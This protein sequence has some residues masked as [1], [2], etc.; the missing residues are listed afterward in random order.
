MTDFWKDGLAAGDAAVKKVIELE[1]ARQQGGIELIASEN[2]VSAAVLEAQGSILTNKYAEGYPGKRY[3]GG[4][5]EVDVVET[6]AIER[7]KELF[8]CAYANVQPHSGSQ[9]NQAVFLA[10]LEPGDTILGLRLDQGGH[11]THGSPVNISGKWFDAH[12]YGVDKE[13]ERIDYDALEAMAMEMKPKLISA[14]ASAYPRLIDFERIGAIAKKVGALFLVDMAHIAGLVAAGLH[15]HPFPHADVVT[16]TTHKTLRGPRGGMIL[17]NSEELAK[18]INSAIF[19]GLQGGPLMHIIAAKAV[20][21]G[22]ALRPDFKGYMQDV[23]TNCDAMATAIAAGGG[24]LVSGGTDNHLCLVDVRPF[25]L[26]GK[27]AEHILEEAGLTC[28][29]NMIPYDV[30]SPFKTSGIRLGS[31]AG[32]TRGFTKDDFTQIGT[33]IAEVLRAA[34]DGKGE[35]VA[36]RVHGEV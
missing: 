3:Y 21:F 8:G 31:A 7:A 35:A 19:P 23:I 6:L 15:P 17:T 18:K 11:L 16:T 30:E 10:C 20:A 12:F 34:R 14:G 22:E 13:S 1:L 33:W 26:N 5:A 4:C 32:T 27:D 28:N 9:T 24:R 36:A 2:Y 29:K 25:G